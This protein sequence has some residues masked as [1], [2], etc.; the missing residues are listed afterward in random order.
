MRLI[1]EE[2]IGTGL[3]DQQ[4]WN[5]NV[6]ENGAYMISISARCKNWLQNFR[7]LFND[8]DLAIQI[9]DYLFAEIRGKKREFASPGSWNGNE[10]KGDVKSVLFLVPIKSGSHQIKFW[11]VVQPIL[12]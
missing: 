6:L 2:K 9:D 8:D 1:K 11:F 4:V 5:F 3:H 12:Y 7:R 10:I